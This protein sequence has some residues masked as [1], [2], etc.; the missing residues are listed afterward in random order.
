MSS[1]KPAPA[2]GKPRIFYGY[3]IVVCTFLTLLV[4][5]GGNGFFGI[6]FKPVS[7]EFHWS[8]AA[9]AAAFSLNSLLGGF[10][11]MIMGKLNDRFG[12]R[13][14]VTLCV[15]LVG[16]GFMLM[17]VINSLWHL[18][19][20]YGVLIGLGMAGAYVPMLSTVARWFSSRLSLMSGIV[21]TGM[22]I[23]E[24][25]AAPVASS[26]IQNY[27]WRDSYLILGAIILMVS[28]AAAQFMKR[29][30]STMG[31][32]PYGENQCEQPS[33]VS[34][35]TLKEAMA[36]RQFWIV[37][38][39]EF[40][41]G[42]ILMTVLVHLVPHVTDLSIPISTAA[43]IMAVCA[44]ASI[45]GRLILGPA[46]DRLGNRAIFLIGFFLMAG[47][48][49]WLIFIRDALPLF[50]CAAVFGF[51]FGGMESSESPIAAWLFGIRNHGLIFGSLVLSFTIGAAIG[52]FLTG[53]IFDTFNS[54]LAAF[55]IMG[56]L[57]MIGF[58]LTATLKPLVK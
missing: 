12:P 20:F 49:T 23:G 34:G 18:F 46:G 44:G 40:A 57:A 37:A 15:I 36:T 50:F 2:P 6:F 1:L 19:F 4:V 8:R 22:S 21:L 33:A 55:I 47:S 25:I 17:S 53:Y 52:P 5:L 26:L 28:V 11:G 16:A 42:F 7:E 9:T 43:A 39:I 41:F 13:L 31:L 45:P 24:L 10:A 35:V 3:I 29:D 48:L 38:A 30:P 54:Y 58:T 27:G 56:V 51:S 14:V 32:K